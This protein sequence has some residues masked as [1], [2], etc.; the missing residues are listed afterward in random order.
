MPVQ[1]PLTCVPALLSRAAA[2]V[3]GCGG[4]A[5]FSLLYRLPSVGRMVAV[6]VCSTIAYVLM[7]AAVMGTASGVGLLFAVPACLLIIYIP[8]FSTM[9]HAAAVT[10]VAQ[11][12]NC[13]VPLARSVA[14]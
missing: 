1:Q 11:G 12:L 3:S 4:F 9:L 2:V 8:F 13:R 5:L 6:A 7:I 10:Y 14:A